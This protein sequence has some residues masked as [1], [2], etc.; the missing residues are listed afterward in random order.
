MSSL[1][2]WFGWRVDASSEELPV[3][4]P[5][6]LAKKDFIEIDVLNIYQK[7]LTDVLERTQGIPQ[8]IQALLWDSCIQSESKDG[9]V[10]MLAKAMSEKKPL[11][12]VYEPALKLVRKATTDEESLIREDYKVKGESTVGIYLSFEKYH[13]TDMV[14][15]YSALEYYT[16]SSL[17]KQ[18]NL[19]A[20]IQFKMS[21]LRTSTGLID[22]AEVKAQAKTIAGAL[23]NGGD[24]LLDAKDEIIT[25]TPQL[26]AIN[27]SIEFLNEKRAF[28]L[29]M[30]K[31]YISGDQTGGIG[32]TGE[33][34][35]KATERGL[36][37]YF[38][39]IIKPVMRA[40]FGLEVTYKSQD[41]RMIDKAL[42]ALQSFSL[43][44][45]E[46]LSLDQ[47]KLIIDRL[48]DIEAESSD[49]V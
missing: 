33:G 25:S 32:S 5:L 36:K 8:D 1:S 31:S 19:S 3:I 41:F 37:N 40:V 38:F 17:N 10:T 6:Q 23:A 39:S 44:D 45:D 26:D 47:K 2:T 42:N 30:P 15:L 34:D 18:S 11:F 24:I 20:A 7:I 28:Y 14:R 12:I 4:F 48:F 21:D 13:R 43:V 27:Q 22:K 46:L 49:Q 9:L 35:V 16:V 29:G